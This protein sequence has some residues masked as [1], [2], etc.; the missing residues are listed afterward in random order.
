M[1]ANAGATGRVRIVAEG[2]SGE[3]VF[4]RG[5]IVSAT[6]ADESGRAALESMS[7]ALFDGEVH[8]EDEDVSVEC[9]PLLE[10][11][12]VEFY[13]QRLTAVRDR[14]ASLVPSLD[15]VPTLVHDGSSGETFAQSMAVRYAESGLMSGRTLHQVARERGLGRTIREVAGLVEAGVVRLDP[16]AGDASAAT[17]VAPVRRVAAGITTRHVGATADPFNRVR[18]QFSR[19]HRPL[20]PRQSA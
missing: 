18:A 16:A 4:Q 15:T 2:W 13:L 11:I 6:L 20:P 7:L 9:E 8:Y 12:D 10:S 14:I 3:I 5:Q 1:I 19:E 17:A